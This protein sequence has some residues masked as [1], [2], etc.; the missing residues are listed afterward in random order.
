[1]RCWY[2]EVA[3]P[4]MELVAQDW[5]EHSRHMDKLEALVQQLLGLHAWATAH[6]FTKVQRTWLQLLFPLV[7][8]A[9]DAAAQLPHPLLLTNKVRASHALNLAAALWTSA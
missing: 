3:R 6:K 9:A 7:P 1:M 2:E 4:L 8:E 5:G